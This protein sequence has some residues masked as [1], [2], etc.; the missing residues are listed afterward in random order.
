MHVA[1]QRMEVERGKSEAGSEEQKVGSGKSEVGS[2]ERKQKGRNIEPK[3]WKAR[4]PESALRIIRRV[5][6]LP[7]AGESTVPGNP[8]L[9]LWT[10]VGANGRSARCGRP[11]AGYIRYFRLSTSDFRLSVPPLRP[12]SNGERRKE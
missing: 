6:A 10:S 8:A 1:A 3:D 5:R 4:T 7:K 9:R 12:A 2:T 11:M